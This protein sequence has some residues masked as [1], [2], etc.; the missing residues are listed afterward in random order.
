MPPVSVSFVIPTRNQAAFLRR[1]LDS[2]L[3]QRIAGAEI[4]VV[5]GLSSDGAQGVLASYGDRIAWTSEPD[6]GQAEAVNKGITRARGE[7]IAWLN[8][9]DAYA[10]PDAVGAVVR[11]FEQDPEVDLVYGRADVVDA[12]GRVIRP[13]S[14][15]RFSR[16]LDVLL[17]P[18]GPPQPAVFFRRALFLAAGGLR[19]DLQYALD[20]DLMVRLFARARRI[21]Y[22]PRTLAHMTFHV[23]A[24]SIRSMRAQIREAVSIKRRYAT[25]LR[26]G[27][28]PR[29]RLVLGIASL[30]AYR[31]AVRLRLR[32]VS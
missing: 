12:S 1:C 25:A 7:I 29:A 26:L 32:R 20:Y 17:A 13:Y 16:S 4:L 14:R 23:D 21:R 11:E 6:S 5:D 27:V 19:P 28:V 30:H 18:I 2:C 10:T 8:S 22:V 3:E 15:R 9:D 31:A 24:K